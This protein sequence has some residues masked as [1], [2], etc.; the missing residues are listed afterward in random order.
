MFVVEK[1]GKYLEVKKKVSGIW[2][3]K[4]RSKIYSLKPHIWIFWAWEMEFPAPLT[5][6]SSIAK[7]KKKKKKRKEKKEWVKPGYIILFTCSNDT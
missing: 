1:A 5:Q 3:E 7:K 4:G 2:T 6:E